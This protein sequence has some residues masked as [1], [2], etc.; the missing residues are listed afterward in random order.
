MVDYKCNKCEMVFKYQSHLDRH[1]KRATPCDQKNEKFSCELCNI[2]FDHKSRLLSHE[3][4][5]KHIINYNI[6]IEN[7]NVTNNNYYGD[8][9][10]IN[11]FNETD[12]NILKENDIEEIYNQNNDLINCFKNFE[13]DDIYPNNIYFVNCFKYFIKIFTKLNFN[14]AYSENH[15]CRCLM[16][17]QINND[18]IEY[19]ILTIDNIVK[20]YGWENINYNI[21]IEKFIDLMSDIDKKFNN[22][23]FK[24]VLE[25][26]NKY[27]YKY[28]LDDNYCKTEIEKSL[29]GEYNKFIKLKVEIDDET[30][31]INTIRQDHLRKLKLIADKMTQALQARDNLNKLSIENKK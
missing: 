18:M 11:A 27:K 16:F 17:K 9:T 1:K 12:I 24:K 28:L 23:N 2:S 30:K 3:K 7:L 15:N 31:L 8:V 10:I 6:H 29:L 25:Y 22:I 4:S 13:D 5:K 26:V 14:L 20:I 21:F 19:Q